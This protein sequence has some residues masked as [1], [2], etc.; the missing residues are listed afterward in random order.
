MN[1]IS[2]ITETLK[3]I[4]IT[5]KRTDSYEEKRYNKIFFSKKK[6]RHYHY[7]LRQMTEFG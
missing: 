1:I 2:K 6:Y 7:S 3:K 4:R 5:D